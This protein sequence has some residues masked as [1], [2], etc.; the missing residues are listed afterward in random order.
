MSFQWGN[1]IRVI[2]IGLMVL[3]ATSGQKV[4]AEDWPRWRGPRLD[5]I[6][7]E[8]GLL[9]EWP[10]EGPKQLWTAPLSGGFSSVA[11][12]DRR[13]FT[14]TR[15]KSQEVVVCLDAATGRDLW[16][17]RYDCDYGAYRTFTG[18]ARPQARTGPRA[19]PAVDGD[20]VYTL[21]ATGILL[22]LEA[23]TGQ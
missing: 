5:G 13:V 12:A 20:R 18:G 3:V 1:T 23:T 16:R 22:C 17:Y 14:Q 11:V 21:G 15:D 10:K 6:S 9:K 8:T 2:S 7:R 19:T 4:W